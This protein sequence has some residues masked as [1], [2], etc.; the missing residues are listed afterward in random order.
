[1]QDAQTRLADGSWSEA[2]AGRATVCLSISCAGRQEKYKQP[3]VPFLQSTF[4]GGRGM[5]LYF[6]QQLH[7]WLQASLWYHR[8]MKRASMLAGVAL[9]PVCLAVPASLAEPLHPDQGSSMASGSSGFR[10]CCIGGTP[11]IL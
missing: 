3:F 11:P 8:K 4:R 7:A 2:A 1:M 5:Q 9:H 6:L 10:R